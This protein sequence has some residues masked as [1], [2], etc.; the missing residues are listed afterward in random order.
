MYMAAFTCVHASVYMNMA[1][2]TCVHASVYMY[3]AA[4]TCVYAS[5]Y[6]YMTAIDQQQHSCETLLCQRHQTILRLL[7]SAATV[8]TRWRFHELNCPTTYV[9]LYLRISKFIQM[10]SFPEVF[11]AQ[12]FVLYHVIPLG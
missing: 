10:L 11:V 12:K 4:C 1:A 5:V 3:M 6:M 7:S 9:K 8:S 2:F